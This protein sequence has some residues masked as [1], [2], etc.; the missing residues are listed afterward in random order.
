MFDTLLVRR[1]ADPDIVKNATTRFIDNIAK[2]KG[3]W[4]SFRLVDNLRNTIEDEHRARNGK[5]HPDHEANYDQFMP[6]V[7]KKHFGE[8]YSDALFQQVAEHEMQ[9]ESEIL[10]ARQ[11]FYGLLD[12][13]KE[14]GKRLFLLSD[15]Y[16][17]LIHI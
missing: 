16:L 13:L 9:M 2:Q 5:E 7:L 11:D 17:S 15:M 10:V 1:V 8:H 14:Q 3:L 12:F 4:S 6:E